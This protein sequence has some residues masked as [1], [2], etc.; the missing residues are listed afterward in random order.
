VEAP[1]RLEIRRI[2][3]ASAATATSTSDIF[4]QI[5][6]FGDYGFPGRMRPASSAR[7]GFV[8]ASATP[9]RLPVRSELAAM[10]FYQPSQLIRIRSGMAC[11]HCRST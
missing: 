9:D 10:G 3:D 4:E 7:L 8:L 2:L 11:A 5:K 1:R 6:G